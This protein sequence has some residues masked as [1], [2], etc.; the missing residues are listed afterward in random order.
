MLV[1]GGASLASLEPKGLERR[2]MEQP[3][4][5]AGRAMSPIRAHPVSHDRASVRL[6]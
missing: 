1:E 2:G 6:T 4:T 3:E 5:K